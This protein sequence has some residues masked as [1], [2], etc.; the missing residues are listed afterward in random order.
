VGSASPRAPV[1][2]G[3]E[4]R[5]PK[6][7]LRPLP[8]DDP[9]RTAALL[10]DLGHDSFARREAATRELAKLADMAEADLGRFLAGAP[11]EEAR[12]QATDLLKNLEPSPEVQRQRWAVVVLR[13]CDRPDARDILKSPVRDCPETWLAQEAQAA[14]DPKA[15]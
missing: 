12:R 10:A 7:A 9:K 3:I 1:A 11:N 15:D 6:T 5:F 14:L 4:R 2:Q 13:A 8:G